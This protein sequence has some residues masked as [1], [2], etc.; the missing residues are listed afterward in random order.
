M[1]TK[2]GQPHHS[3]QLEW[4][5]VAHPEMRLFAYLDSTPE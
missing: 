3:T 2:Q 4:R 5:L 1:S